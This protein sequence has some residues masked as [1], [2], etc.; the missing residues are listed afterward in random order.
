MITYFPLNLY[1]EAGEWVIGSICYLIFGVME[2]GYTGL[3]RCGH[4]TFARY[5]FIM[6]VNNRYYEEF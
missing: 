2:R 5:N 4:C 1:G 6:A 3:F